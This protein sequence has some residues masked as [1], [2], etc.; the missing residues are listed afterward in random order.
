MEEATKKANQTRKNFKPL[1]CQQID[2][3][4]TRKSCAGLVQPSRVVSSF[5]SQNAAKRAS[6]GKRISIDDEMSLI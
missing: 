5:N 1:C 4:V 3:P 2:I 6:H